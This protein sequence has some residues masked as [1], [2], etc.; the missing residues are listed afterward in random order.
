MGR[1]PRRKCKPPLLGKAR[2]RAT[3]L[4]PENLLFRQY[5]SR[6]VLPRA[7]R[8]L[9]LS[10]MTLYLRSVHDV[11]PVLQMQTLYSF[12]LQGIE[13]QG[14]RKN[15]NLAVLHN[16]VVPSRY[17]PIA[18]G[19]EI[20]GDLHAVVPAVW[21]CGAKQ[22]TWQWCK[23]PPFWCGRASFPKPNLLARIR[24][25]TIVQLS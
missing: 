22:R 3:C 13:N 8:S 21:V 11:T 9:F 23:A 18:R 24:N 5:G 2:K 20:C 19:A 4:V 14:I 6:A 15:L 12:S 7:M 17:G 25:L 16:F 1:E 10:F